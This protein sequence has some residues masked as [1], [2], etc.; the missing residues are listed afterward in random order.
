MGIERLR[1]DD[2]EKR[3]DMEKGKML[4]D[5]PCVVL[6][7]PVEVPRSWIP[8]WA[9]PGGAREPRADRPHP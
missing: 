2:I 6:M 9:S 4:D 1:E 5:L 8:K 7:C 3:R